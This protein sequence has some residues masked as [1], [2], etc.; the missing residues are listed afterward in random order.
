MPAEPSLTFELTVPP[1]WEAIDLLAQARR[2]NLQARIE[3]AF[4]GNPGLEGQG[5]AMAE[6][7][8]SGARVGD[9]A[10]ILGIYALVTEAAAGLP[11][12]AGV[13]VS[14]V[15]PLP[16]PEPGMDGREDLLGAHEAAEWAVVRLAI[17]DAVR[18]R[19]LYPAEILP[20]LEPLLMLSLT[21]DVPRAEL[22]GRLLTL[23]FSTLQAAVAP[24]LC[25]LFDAIAARCT[26]TL[27]GAAA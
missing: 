6:A 23:A 3:Q 25:G 19:R 21:Y 1:G 2:G 20:G 16:F 10:G 26:L 5:E 7:V 4:V 14:L 9:G 24:E 18:V 8:K 11:L 13:T 12:V 27:A 15:D 22:G 17:G